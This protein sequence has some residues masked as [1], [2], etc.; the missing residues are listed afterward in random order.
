MKLCPECKDIK[1]L[2]H[3]YKDKYQP[4][5]YRTYCK[6]CCKNRVKEYRRRTG[7]KSTEEVKAW[8]ANNKEKAAAGYKRTY[9]KN[10]HKC[11]CR[12]ITG[13][14]V[15]DGRL[16][17]LPCECGD[18]NVEAHHH[19]YDKPLDVTWMCEKCHRKLHRKESNGK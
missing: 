18:T 10:K 9:E 5:G 11:H 3:F 2:D 4:S 1:T 14:A 13:Q 8:R 17:K 12:T 16:I 6:R 15:K 19:D 7:Y